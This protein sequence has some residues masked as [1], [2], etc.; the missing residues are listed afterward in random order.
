MA[1]RVTFLRDFQS[2]A[3]EGARF[4]AGDVWEFADGNAGALVAEGAAEYSDAP[5]VYDGVELPQDA[6]VKEPKKKVKV[7]PKHTP[8]AKPEPKSTKKAGSK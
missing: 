1:T 7:T 5:L 2:D 6:E 8:V 4:M 3:T